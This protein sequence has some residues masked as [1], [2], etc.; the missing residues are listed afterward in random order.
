LLKSIK[1]IREKRY[2]CHEY[3]T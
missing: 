3:C 1:N 2:I